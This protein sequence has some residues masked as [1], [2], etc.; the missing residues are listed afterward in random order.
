MMWWLLLGAGVGL[1]QA[2]IFVLGR[3]IN[4][5]EDDDG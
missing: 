1:W 2:A 4:R 5:R 3:R